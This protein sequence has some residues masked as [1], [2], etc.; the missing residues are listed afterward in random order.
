V[1]A[2]ILDGTFC[3]FGQDVLQTGRAKVNDDGA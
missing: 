2:L 1:A 3:K